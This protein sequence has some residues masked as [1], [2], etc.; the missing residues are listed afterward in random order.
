MKSLW[1]WLGLLACLAVPAAAQLLTGI[2][3]S[4]SGGGTPSG[5]CTQGKLDFSGS[6]QTVFMVTVL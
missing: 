1:F 4:N 2:S 6:C 3:Q 5:A